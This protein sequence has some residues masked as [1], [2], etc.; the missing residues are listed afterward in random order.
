MNQYFKEMPELYIPSGILPEKTEELKPIVGNEFWLCGPVLKALATDFWQRKS[1][2][3]SAGLV[4]SNI[5]LSACSANEVTQSPSTPTLTTIPVPLPTP[6]PTPVSIEGDFGPPVNDEKQ[7]GYRNQIGNYT[8]LAANKEDGEYLTQIITRAL[9]IPMIKNAVEKNPRKTIITTFLEHNPGEWGRSSIE[10]QIESP[11]LENGFFNGQGIELTTRDQLRETIIAEIN[12][13]SL[14]PDVLNDDALQESLAIVVAAQEIL[15]G[16]GGI[17]EL[18]MEALNKYGGTVGESGVTRIVTHGFGLNIQYDDNTYARTLV[19]GEAATD[20]MTISAVKG[21]IP[22]AHFQVAKAYIEGNSYAPPHSFVLESI[23]AKDTHFVDTMYE[24]Y[25]TGDYIKLL[26]LMES[27]LVESP[28]KNSDQANSS[29]S[30]QERIRRAYEQ[31][32][33]FHKSGIT[34]I[35]DGKDPLRDLLLKQ[36]LIDPNMRKAIGVK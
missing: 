2:L 18:D 36:N 15:H 32:S 11:L 19:I 35:R 21:Y 27:R 24:Y 22:D 6:L 8:L 20:L 3:L 9:D 31:V 30:E 17:R 4:I 12:A 16:V 28:I 7:R 23:A 26:P 25:L 5:F 1:S 29:L 14:S 33:E 13:G 10:T 34:I